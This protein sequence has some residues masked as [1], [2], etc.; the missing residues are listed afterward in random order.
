MMDGLT[1][2]LH[3]KRHLPWF[4]ILP[5]GHPN[6]IEVEHQVIGTAMHFLLHTADGFIEEDPWNL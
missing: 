6:L 3:R 2:E 5:L 4:A 1:S